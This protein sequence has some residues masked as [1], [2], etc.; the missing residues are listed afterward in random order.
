MTVLAYMAEQKAK[1]RARHSGEEFFFQ[2]N[3][4]KNAPLKLEDYRNASAILE[5]IDG[6]K[7]LNTAERGFFTRRNAFSKKNGFAV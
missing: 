5:E 3:E 7:G 2:C 6:M 1:I 4:D